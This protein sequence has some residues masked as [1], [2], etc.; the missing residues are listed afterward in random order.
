MNGT[1]KSRW[2]LRMLLVL[3]IVLF[4]GMIYV[5]EIALRGHPGLLSNEVYRPQVPIS[6]KQQQ[7][8]DCQAKI[9]VGMTEQQVEKLLADF[10]NVKK[11][12]QANAAANSDGDY[13]IYY[14]IPPGAQDDGLYITVHFDKHGK[15]VIS[16]GG[17]S[18][19]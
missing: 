10:P 1:R 12:R 14:R 18:D 5:A 17:Q 7:F 15:V 2:V 19:W 3:S 16:R 9:K 4:A 8:L 11:D 13:W 6:A